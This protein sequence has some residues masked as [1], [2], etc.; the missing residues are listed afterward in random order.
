M[1]LDNCL[2]VSR[3]LLIADFLQLRV[4]LLNAAYIGEHITSKRTTM[5]AKPLLLNKYNYSLSSHNIKSMAFK[6]VK[7]QFLP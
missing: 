1:V 3:S 7:I 2:Q 5:I 4:T 6:R